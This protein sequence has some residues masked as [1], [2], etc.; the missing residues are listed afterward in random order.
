MRK[1]Y[2][3]EKVNNQFRE[4]SVNDLPKFITELK[5]AQDDIDVLKKPPPMGP[6][7][8]KVWNCIKISK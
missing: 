7:I 3:E 4:F 5:K 1:D 6:L 2:I 8:Q